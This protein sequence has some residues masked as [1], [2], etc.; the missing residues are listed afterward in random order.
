MIQ[1]TMS[2]GINPEFL[3]RRNIR[4]LQFFKFFG[5]DIRIVGS[6][7]YPLIIYNNNKALSCF[8]KEYE[9]NLTDKNGFKGN[10]LIT[11]NLDSD[12]AKIDED[13][14]KII[15]DWMLNTQHTWCKALKLNGVDL[16]FS[17]FDYKNRSQK[18]GKF[19]IFSTDAYA[20]YIDEERLESIKQELED[21]FNIFTTIE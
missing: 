3:K 11:I 19:A 1:T 20:V 10:I 17:S 2:K 13:Q 18:I 4:V 7:Q 12:F 14:K 15:F 9:L 16:F 6:A 21:V 5:Y 8:L